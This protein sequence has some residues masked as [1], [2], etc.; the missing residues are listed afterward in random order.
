MAVEARGKIGIGSAD[1]KEAAPWAFEE[2]RDK[3]GG[4]C[5]RTCGVP[6]GGKRL[7]D[8]LCV[9]RWRKGWKGRGGTAWS[10]REGEPEG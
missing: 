3:N 1:D 10:V 5:R 2:P 7:E 8:G 4:F 6:C 9:H